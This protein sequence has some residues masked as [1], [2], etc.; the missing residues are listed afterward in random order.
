VHIVFQFFVW[1]EAKAIFK[2]I[3]PIGYRHVH[4]LVETFKVHEFAK[5]QDIK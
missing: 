3:F 2:R 4:G 1:R 5:N